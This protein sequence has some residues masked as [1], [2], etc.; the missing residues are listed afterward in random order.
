MASSSYLRTVS[1]LSQGLSQ[2]LCQRATSKQGSADRCRPFAET[3]AHNVWNSL[4]DKGFGE[5]C[6]QR[7]DESAPREPH[8]ATDDDNLRSLGSFGQ[9]GGHDSQLG[10]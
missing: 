4:P 7:V 2:G 1:G 9:R 3:R 6:G 8:A 10:C 5:A